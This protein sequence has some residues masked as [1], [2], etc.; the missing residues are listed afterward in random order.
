MGT[1][2][3]MLQ[4]PLLLR[5]CSKSA[6]VPSIADFS[7]K[8]GNV[9]GLT[10]SVSVALIYLLFMEGQSAYLTENVHRGCLCISGVHRRIMNQDLF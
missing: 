9:P 8:A 3:N 2:L 10:Q 5:H 4:I 1:S 6:C 7:F